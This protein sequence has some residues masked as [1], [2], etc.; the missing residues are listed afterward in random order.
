MTH[1]ACYQ[2]QRPRPLYGVTISLAPSIRLAAVLRQF[3]TFARSLLRQTPFLAR[4]ARR[5][6]PTRRSIQHPERSSTSSSHRVS[7]SIPR[8]RHANSFPLLFDDS[9]TRNNTTRRQSHELRH[10]KHVRWRI[11]RASP[12]RPSVHR[13]RP[14]Q[15]STFVVARRPP[16]HRVRIRARTPRDRAARQI[17]RV[18]GRGKREKRN[19]EEKRD[20]VEARL[21]EQRLD[22]VPLGWRWCAAP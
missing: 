4:L 16:V 18:S 22:D 15:L 6:L 7:T 21:R 1:R 19:G 14:R 17:V 5:L 10:A 2:P 8:E 3:P 13:P 20:E 9:T 11:A 12:P